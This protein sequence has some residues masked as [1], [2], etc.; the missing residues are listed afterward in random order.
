MR[1]YGSGKFRHRITKAATLAPAPDSKVIETVIALAAQPTEVE[2][3]KLEEELA[4]VDSYAA[5]S[6]QQPIEPEQP[7]AADVT[8]EAIADML[9]ETEPAESSA[10]AS[11]APSAPIET[12]AAAA[13]RT[14]LTR[15]S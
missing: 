10:V 6:N 1:T 4:V 15:K 5:D 7:V 12:V 2:R 9:E 3:T 11:V 14:K 8:E 13:P